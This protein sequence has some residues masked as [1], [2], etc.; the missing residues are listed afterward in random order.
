MFLKVIFLYRRMTSR[1]IALALVFVAGP[2]SAASRVRLDAR[3][4]TAQSAEQT[5][6]TESKPPP[7]AFVRVC[8]KCHNADRIIEGR[9]TRAQWGEVIEAMVAKGAEGTDDDFAV[10][11]EH[12][13]SEYG[14]VRINAASAA[15]VAEV[16]HLQKA[17]ADL[18]VDYRTKHGKFA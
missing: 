1:C 2:F 12:L 3:V 16:L 17:A 8:G 5:A 10:I 7:A 9:R 11:V 15:E 14:R 4:P 13:V 18:I 6:S